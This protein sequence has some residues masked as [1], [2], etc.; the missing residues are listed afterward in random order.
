MRHS[1]ESGNPVSLIINGLKSLGPRFRGDDTCCFP[2]LSIL[3]Q[4]QE[5][6]LLTTGTFIWGFG[7]LLI[8]YL[9]YQ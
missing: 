6:S 9:M 1:R 7:D 2:P 8:E 3:R 4:V 5:F